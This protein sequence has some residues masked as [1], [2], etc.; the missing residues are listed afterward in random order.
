M[1]EARIFKYGLT[2]D[3]DLWADEIQGMGMEGIRFRFH[4]RPSP[5]DQVDRSTYECRY[6]ADTV[7][8]QRCVPQPSA[9]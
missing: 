9:W 7:S 8:I 1:T 2:P 3:A 5:Q 4:Y 6:W